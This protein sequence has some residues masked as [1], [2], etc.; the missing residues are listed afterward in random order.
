MKLITE[1]IVKRIIKAG[2]NVADGELRLPVDCVLTPAA[3]DV[4]SN[5]RLK[6][7]LSD[8]PHRSTHAHPEATKPEYMTHLNKDTLV[9]KDNLRICLRG[10]VDIFIAEI[11]KVQIRAAA[12]GTKQLVDDLEDDYGIVRELSRSEIQ[13]E[14]FTAN[15]VI[16]LDYSEIR[17]VSHHPKHYFGREHLFNISYKDGELTVLLNSLRAFSRRC[18]LVFY[19]AFKQED[20]TVTRPDLA[21]GYN[22]LSSIIYILCLRAASGQYEGVSRGRFI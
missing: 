5:A 4:V 8:A 11:L 2:K 12:L 16:G 22:R 20:N 13:D 6:L 21:E 14:P 17:K 15:T 10:E 9:P 7:N 3:R 1:D 19:E 18:E